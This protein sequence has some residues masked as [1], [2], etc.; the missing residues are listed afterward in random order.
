MQEKLEK[1][2]YIIVNCFVPL[3]TEILSIPS[4]VSSEL[5][6]SGAYM[7]TRSGAGYLKGKNPIYYGQ[8]HREHTVI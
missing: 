2:K 8:I 7:F 3:R 1:I 5:W 4:F 6:A